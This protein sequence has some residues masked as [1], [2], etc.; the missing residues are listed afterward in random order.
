M[1]PMPRLLARPDA[2]PPVGEPIWQDP[3]DYTSMPTMGDALT[4]PDE[5]A[6]ALTV[7]DPCG[8]AVTAAQALRAHRMSDAGLVDALVAIERQIAALHGKQQ[9]FLAELA[10]RD[11]DGQRYLRDEAAC[12]LKLAPATAAQRLDEALELTG[13][14]FD[15]NELVAGGYLS[16]ANARILARAVLD[17]PDDVAVKVQERVLPRGCGQTPGEFRATV[18]RAVAR[19]DRNDEAA[20]HAQAYAQR[21]VIAYPTGDYMA[22]V[23]L[24][25]AAD[26]A[27]VVTTAVNAWAVKTGT[28]DH[29]TADQRRA[30][31]IVDIC[32]AA[33]AMPGLPR[34]HGLKPSINVTV[35][36]T[37]LLGLSTEPGLLDGYGPI[38]AEIA[39]RLAGD[40]SSTWRRLLTDQAGRLLDYGSTVYKPPTALARHVID[41]DQ[42]C[43]HPG[44]RRP[45]A[46]CELD[47]RVPWPQGPTSA[48]NLQP[49]CK[50]H[51]HLKHHSNWRIRRCDDGSYQWQS[52]TRHTYR[53]RPPELPAPQQPDPTQQDHDHPPPF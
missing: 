16:P 35:P 26:G 31:A 33:L 23:V 18:R 20:K 30:D 7:L 27:E 5:A 2:V 34:Q 40:P 25:L 11:P 48:E 43:V 4:H 47:H 13:R 22:D 19:F 17:L 46:N 44:C 36:F 41:R 10:R 3:A 38:P 51:H 50:R 53:Y 14:L 9:E 39:C 45:A 42:Y 52:P 12:A 28:D 15:A 21:H 32:T 49:L 6:S 37:T 1:F 8:E 29:R 24:H